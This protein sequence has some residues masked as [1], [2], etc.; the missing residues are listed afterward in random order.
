MLPS[1]APGSFRLQEYRSGVA[2]DVSLVA[3]SS[4]RAEFAEGLVVYRG[5]TL[6]QMFCTASATWAPKTSS[7]FNTNQTRPRFD[8]RSRSANRS[9]VFG[10]WPIRSSSS[11]L[12][13]PHD[14]APRGRRRR[15]GWADCARM[16]LERGAL[17]SRFRY[18]AGDGEHDHAKVP[19]CCDRACNG[20][21]EACNEEASLGVCIRRGGLHFSK[22]RH[23]M[24]HWGP[25]RSMRRCRL[26]PPPLSEWL[27]AYAPSIAG[28]RRRMA[29]RSRLRLRWEPLGRYLVAALLEAFGA[30]G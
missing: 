23:Q 19:R 29:T 12:Q 30:G 2:V 26:L 21:C 27:L 1:T 6:G 10:W 4:A 13:G 24:S 16:A 17:R 14:C 11:T 7:C 3:A 20:Q 8:M 9:L 22:P 15:L 5:R 18:L 28:G 25:S